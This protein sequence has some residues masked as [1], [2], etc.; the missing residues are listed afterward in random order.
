[1]NTIKT[2][3]VTSSMINSYKDQVIIY[4]DETGNIELYADIGKDTIWATQAQI[5]Q[6]FDVN[7]QAITKHLKN[8]YSNGE[9]SKNLTCSKMEQVQIEG[10]RTIK[11]F[12]ESYNLDAV[13]AVGYRINSKKATQF[14]IWATK[15]LHAHLVRGYTL[16]RYGL[17]ESDEKLEG[18]HDAIT[19]LESQKHKGKLKGKLTLKLTKTLEAK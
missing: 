6:I 12:V 18:L 14:R 11:R 13:I 9:L 17:I 2:K 4:S 19:L 7:S 10:Q 3:V 5:A 15:I 16:D 8:I 1:M